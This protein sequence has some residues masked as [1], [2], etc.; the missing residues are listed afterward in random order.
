MITKTTKSVISALGL[1]IVA[2]GLAA[3]SASAAERWRY[4]ADKRQAR[5]HDLI[6]EGRQMGTLT[7]FETMKLRREQVRIARMERAF[8]ADGHLSWQERQTLRYAQDNATQHIFE[9]RNNA[10]VRR[11]W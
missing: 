6:R 10:R 3:S 9:H 5:Q 1:T 2:A 11:Y 7:W 8:R 4:E